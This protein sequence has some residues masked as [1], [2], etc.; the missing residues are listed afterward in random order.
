[1]KLRTDYE[2]AIGYLV[3]GWCPWPILVGPAPGEVAGDKLA[4]CRCGKWVR[5]TARGLYA[6]HKP[7]DR[8]KREDLDGYKLGVTE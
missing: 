3:S 4:K 2:R 5:V 7:H 1:M 8:V 6:H